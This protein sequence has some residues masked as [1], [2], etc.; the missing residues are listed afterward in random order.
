MWVDTATSSG[1]VATNGSSA[2]SA[3][4]RIAASPSESHE[5]Q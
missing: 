2:S 5:R 4:G 3:C 1:D